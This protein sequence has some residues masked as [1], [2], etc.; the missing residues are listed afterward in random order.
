MRT[1]I[2]LNKELVERLMATGKYKSKRELVEAG[3]QELERQRVL[4]FV[5]SQR[6]KFGPW[7][8]QI[9]EGRM[10]KRAK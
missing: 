2:E 3:L 5:R 9:E 10:G 6:G 7:D 4:E 8:G 1:N